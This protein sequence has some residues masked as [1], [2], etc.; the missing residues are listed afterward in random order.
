MSVTFS[1]LASGIDSAALVDQLVAAESQPA[2]ALSTKVSNLTR[3]G[4]IV[5]DLVSKLRALG[6]R[7]RGLDL[8]SEVRA[9]KIT[10]SDE[11]HVGAAVS[12]GASPSV[13][14]LRVVSTA[15][16]QT[17]SSDP[18]TGDGPGVI[19]AGSVTIGGGDGD[20]VTITW[21]DTDSLSAIAARINDANAAAS[22]AVVFDG[23]HHRL[24]ATS[25]A[26]GT[27]AA[28][29]FTETG[30]ALGWSSPANVTAAARDAVFE[31]DGITVVRGSNVVSDAL[32]GVTLTL[33]AAH[34]AG[35]PDTTLTVAADHEA[36]RDKV[37]GLIDAYNLV[38][39]A[40][41]GQLRYTG[42]A[43]GSDTLFGDATLRQLQGALG[44]LVTDEHGGK[45]LGG[46]GIRVDTSGRLSLDASRFDA[47]IAADPAAVERLFVDGGLGAG[48]AAL[49]D[50]YARGGDG[51]LAAKTKAIDGRV[52]SHRKDIERIEAAAA[53]AGDRLRAQFTALERAISTMRTQTSQ[54]LSILGQAG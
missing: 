31:L 49:T 50:T 5:N 41:D 48:L 12:A 7:S 16:G 43:K 38:A 54:M 46:L 52:A 35:A 19:G 9:L 13:H 17:V 42:T 22:A 25:R 32:A 6:D 53:A 39:G 27:A 26:T 18:F 11:G 23:T 10:R 4:S 51:M 8:A 44:R 36:V 34:A 24:V 47:A 2:K 33:T 40:L 1:G 15:R 28:P 45:T 3:Q 37:K 30:A 20:P 21:S 29:T 14:S